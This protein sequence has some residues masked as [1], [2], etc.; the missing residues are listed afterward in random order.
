MTHSPT[1]THGSTPTASPRGISKCELL[2]S[3]QAA[4]N[5]CAEVADAYVLDFA[6]PEAVLRG[7]FDLVVGSECVYYDACAAVASGG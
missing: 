2:I 5:Y 7:E 4:K 6:R 3:A 1:H